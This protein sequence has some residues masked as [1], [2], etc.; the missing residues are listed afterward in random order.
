MDKFIGFD[1]DHKHTLACVTQAGRPERY[2]KLR[3]EVGQL[4][5]CRQAR[6]VHANLPRRV[7]HL[8]DPSFLDGGSPSSGRPAVRAVR[9]RFLP[10]PPYGLQ[11]GGD[12]FPGD[13]GLVDVVGWTH[14][15]SGSPQRSDT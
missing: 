15:Q 2:T 5:E 11:E 8:G 3:T 1:V 13:I 4:R 7:V 10:I 12:V 14:D 9:R 6:R